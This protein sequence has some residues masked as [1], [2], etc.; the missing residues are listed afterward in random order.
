[1][2]ERDILLVLR[3]TRV[4]MVADLMNRLA[5]GKITKRNMDSQR[6]SAFKQARKSRAAVKR[7]LRGV[8]QKGMQHVTEELERQEATDG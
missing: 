5:E 8:G 7:V 4:A 6:R 3:E 1:M 2:G